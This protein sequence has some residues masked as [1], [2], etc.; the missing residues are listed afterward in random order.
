MELIFIKRN[1]QIRIYIKDREIALFANGIPPIMI[2]LDKL[3][4]HKERIIAIGMS[5]KEIEEIAALANEEQIAE[6]IKDDL[7]KSGWRLIG[8]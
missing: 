6:S 7:F 1:A 8:N 4:E 5:R 3:E 2:N